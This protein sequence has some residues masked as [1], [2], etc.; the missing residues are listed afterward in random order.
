[1]Y[2]FLKVR[3]LLGKMTTLQLQNYANIFLS[4]EDK[5]KLYQELNLN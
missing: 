2:D 5:E 4:E 3:Y 1:M